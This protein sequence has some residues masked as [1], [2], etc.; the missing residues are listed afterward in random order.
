MPA[1]WTSFSR[2]TAFSG[3]LALSK[4]SASKSAPVL[5]SG[6]ITWTDTLMLLLPASVEIDPPM[7]SIWSAICSAVRVFVPFTKTL[8][9][10]RVSPFVSRVSASN[11]LRKTALIA[12]SGRRGS[13]RTSKRSPFESSNFW[14]SAAAAGFEISCLAPSEPFGL[15]DVTVRFWST[16]YFTATRRISS[17][18]T[19]WIAVK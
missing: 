4:T 14:I 9:V 2:A 11:P 7:A 13:S 17:S 19:F 5:R 12:T 6:F 16:R 1:I 8:A 3:K 10:R 15:S 18:V